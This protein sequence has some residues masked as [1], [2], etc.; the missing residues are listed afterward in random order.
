MPITS[1]GEIALIADIEA[2]FDQTGTEDISLVQA[3][4]DAGLSTTDA[5]MFGF[6]GESDVALGAITTN[7][8]SSVSG[9]GMTLNGNI[10][11]D[12]G[13]TITDHGFYFGTSSTYTSNTKVSLGSGSVGSYSS[14]RTG[15]NS[16]T[17]YYATAYVVNSVGETV[18]STVSAAT[19]FVYATANLSTLQTQ[20]LTAQY[21]TTIYIFKQYY[22]GYQVLNYPTSGTQGY[23]T[24]STQTN[25]WLYNA[26]DKSVYTNAQ[27]R[28]HSYFLQNTSYGPHNTYTDY[29]FKVYKSGNFSNWS[30]YL[31]TGSGVSFSMT[32]AGTRSQLSGY[33]NRGTTSYST[34]QMGWIFNW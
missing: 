33:G 31:A 2:E 29:Y 8:M 14:V 9:S 28:V 12:G 23:T 4:T 32:S 15:L 5:S 26:P 10:T 6:Y 30:Q 1:S 13:G 21:Y 17:T 27:M 3:A 24:G 16:Q 20:L 25:N 22:S 11:S 18:G 19:P 34:V 7:S